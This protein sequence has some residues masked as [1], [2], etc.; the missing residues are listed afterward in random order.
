MQ[1]V[2]A[3]RR[4]S[5]PRVQATSP[6]P[7]YMFVALFKTDSDCRIISIHNP[8]LNTNP[9][10]VFVNDN[11]ESAGS[12]TV[13]QPIKHLGDCLLHSNKHLSLRCEEKASRYQ[14]QSRGYGWQQW[15][16]LMHGGVL[17]QSRRVR[18]TSADFLQQ[19]QMVS[20]NRSFMA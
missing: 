20:F 5:L 2:V 1:L 8:L 4:V 16:D 11:A 10:A 13:G 19:L 17:H 14:F 6:N 15:V 18:T 3:T 12:T 7:E 9:Y